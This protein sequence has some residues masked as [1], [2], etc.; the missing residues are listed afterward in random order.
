MDPNFAPPSD[1]ISLTV[2]ELLCSLTNQNASFITYFFAFNY[3]FSVL[4]P[5][6]CTSLSQSGCVKFFKYIISCGILRGKYYKN[7][8]CKTGFNNR[9]QF[10]ERRFFDSVIVVKYDCQRSNENQRSSKRVVLNNP[11][12]ETSTLT[13]YFSFYFE[14]LFKL[15]CAECTIQKTELVSVP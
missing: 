13:P 8:L 14:R 7:W 10:Q 4:L 2:R 15:S 1:C 11:Q 3:L 12:L 6:N 9:F 5:K